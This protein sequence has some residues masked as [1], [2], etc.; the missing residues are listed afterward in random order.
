[1][2]KIWYISQLERKAEDGFVVNVHWRLSM[3]DTDNSG[4]T[5]YAD[6]YSVASYTQREEDV[7]PF[8]DLTKEIVV[9]WVKESIG[10]EAL[11]SIENHLIQ[12]IEAQKNPPI[13]TGLPW[14]NVPETG[15][16]DYEEG[17]LTLS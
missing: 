2:E 5:Y 8:E 14:E 13:L 9:G 12:Q 17:N 10:E 4:K 3:T 1:M 15:T 16:L 11:Q 6:T 7:I